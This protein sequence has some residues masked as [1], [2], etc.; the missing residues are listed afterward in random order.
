MRFKDWKTG[1]LLTTILLTVLATP[2]AFAGNYERTYTSQAQFGL[3]NHQLHVSIPQSL[4]DYY[5]GTTIKLTNDNQY[6]TLVTPDAV[7][8]IADI[9]RNLTD[10]NPRKDEEFANAVLALI[11]QIP[12]EITPAIYP[13]ETIV[14]NQGKCD[15]LSLLAASIMKAGQLDVVLLYFKDTHHMN[16]GV[17]LPYEPHTT[18]WWLQPTGYQYNNKTYWIAE[19]TPAME[20]KVG[21]VPPILTDETPTIISLE[22]SEPSSPAHVS[23]KLG[24]TLDA[25]AIT[26]SL[27]QNSTYTSSTKR[28][29]TITGSIT[30]PYPNQ[31]ITVYTSQD[32]TNFS[33]AKTQ[34]DNNGNYTYNWNTTTT[35]T[36]YIKTSWSGNTNH[37][38]TDSQTLTVFLGFPQTLIQY[39]GPGY[40]YIYGHAYASRHVLRVRQGVDNF[41]DIQLNGTG[42]TLTGEFTII[43][44]GQLLTI[45]K[46]LEATQT[47]QATTVPKGTQ[48]LR[49]PDDIEYSTNN[50]FCFIMQNNGPN[51]YTLNVKAL[52]EYDIGRLTQPNREQTAF[53]NTSGSIKENEWYKIVAKIT[54]NE[55]TAE[56]QD[57]N[58]TALE[59]IATTDTTTNVNELVLLLANNTDRAIAFKNLN[60]E[61]LYQPIQPLEDDTKTTGTELLAPNATLPILLA[62]VFT[63]AFYLK[64]RKTMRGP[65]LTKSTGSKFNH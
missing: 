24:Q 4:Y 56:L 6:A 55:I 28:T 27:T 46:D 47:L 29:L 64:K 17:Y 14:E 44:S 2:A 26:I 32:G 65:A 34:T 22:N 25:S 21:D 31:T 30:P 19:C 15:T 58:G 57:A 9:L 42:I 52:N 36:H 7:K 48:P 39:E 59:K 45:P 3:V 50:Q 10:S 62:T 37:T 40:Y 8:P 12:Y 54:E 53:M 23:A 60:V 38:A 16:V 43:K 5:H 13:I 1:L 41:L 49:L 63:A 18:W 20:W 11:H 35:G 61:P 33:T 51:N